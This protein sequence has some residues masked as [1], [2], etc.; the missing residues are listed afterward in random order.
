MRTKSYK[1]KIVDPFV[2]KLKALVKTILARC[3]ERW[4]N[5]HRL[6]NTSRQLYQENERLKKTNK[7]LT[8]DNEALRSENKDYK[9]LRKVFGRQMD[10]QITKAKEFRQSK[11]QDARLRSS[12]GEIR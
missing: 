3:F 9:L 11:K 12:R 8:A 6:N 5:Y 1:H 10:D 4:D 2:R 7:Q